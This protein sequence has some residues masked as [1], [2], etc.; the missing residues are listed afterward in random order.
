M[1]EQVAVADVV[2]VN[3]EFTKA[4]VHD[5]T[6][7]T[8]TVAYPAADLD[9]FHPRPAARA[10][11]PTLLHVGRVVR[12][13]GQD[14][15][16][17]AFAALRERHPEAV[18]RI[19]GRAD[20][21]EYCERVRARAAEIGNVEF[22]GGLGMDELVLE[23][24]RAWVFTCPSLFEGF[25]MPFLEAEA[26]GTPC[27]GLRV[28]SVPEVVKEGETGLLVDEGDTA[29]LADAI[30][31]LLSDVDLRAKMSAAARPWAERFGWGKSARIIYDVLNQHRA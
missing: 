18:L 1:L 2:F 31:E 29:A 11:Q 15:L 16:L 12:H 7:K 25:G 6:G 24:Q 30:D 27:V 14:L 28:C 4:R 20:S 19:V 9:L 22:A 21:S 5:V 23:Y 3:S 17:E 26:C 13:K 10:A 8:A